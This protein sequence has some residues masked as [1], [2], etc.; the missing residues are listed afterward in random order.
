MYCCSGCW[1]EFDSKSWCHQVELFEGFHKIDSKHI[2]YTHTQ[3]TDKMSSIEIWGW[4]IYSAFLVFIEMIFF[5]FF[6]CIC[7]TQHFSVL[8]RAKTDKTTFDEIH[9]FCYWKP[10]EGINSGTLHIQHT[11]LYSRANSWYFHKIKNER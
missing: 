4:N 11:I 9:L 3:P 8:P 6:V 7:C 2:A 10:Y 1:N 5:C